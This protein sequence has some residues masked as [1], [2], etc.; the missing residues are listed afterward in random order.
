MI[1][2]IR[3]LCRAEGWASDSEVQYCCLYRGPG[4]GIYEHELDHIYVFVPRS[5][6]VGASLVHVHHDCRV[7]MC[8]RLTTK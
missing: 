1:L 4:L 5:K 2:G 6:G 8:S 7:L 3:K